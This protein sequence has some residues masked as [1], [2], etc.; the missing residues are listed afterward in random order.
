MT[1]Y[2]EDFTVGE[3][4]DLGSLT[5]DGDEML[6]FARRFDPQPF[7]VDEEL[8]KE[9]PFGGL[10]AS[11]WFTA[12]L[13]MR[14]YVD[15]VLADSTSQGSPGLSELRWL[16]PVRAGDVLD[17]RLTVL[18]STPSRTKP[19]R[20]TVV[21]RGELTRAGQPVLSTTFRGL[22]GRRPR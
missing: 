16:S 22:F 9:T 7:H 5:V 21:L 17:G 8:A 19:T 12:S 14:L 11:G 15:A 2:W 3:S 4:F 18:E 1:R 6:A 13:F 10:I 20:G